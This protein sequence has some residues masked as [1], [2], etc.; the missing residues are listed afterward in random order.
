MID[1]Y[2]R[3]LYNEYQSRAKSLVEEYLTDINNGYFRE[4]GIEDN[5]IVKI[6]REFA[7]NEAGYNAWEIKEG[8]R[9]LEKA[10]DPSTWRSQGYGVQD[11]YKQKYGAPFVPSGD[12][13]GLP[14]FGK[15]DYD[16]D[17]RGKLRLPYVT[18]VSAGGQHIPGVSTPIP[19][20]SMPGAYKHWFDPAS[21]IVY[22]LETQQ[23]IFDTNDNNIWR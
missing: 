22:D 16:T 10:P 20:E 3:K 18:D 23:K 21:G 4:K 14:F 6:D 11:V 17:I 15:A 12:I 2:G 19:P 13:W 9:N 7:K 8:L 1:T 5:P